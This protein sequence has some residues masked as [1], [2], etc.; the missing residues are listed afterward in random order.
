M[1]K[2]AKGKGD[3]AKLDPKL[4]MTGDMDMRWRLSPGQHRQPIRVAARLSPCKVSSYVLK[5]GEQ[6]QMKDYFRPK[7]VAS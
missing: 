3:P 1:C 5:A 7:E 4:E 6:T 2:Q